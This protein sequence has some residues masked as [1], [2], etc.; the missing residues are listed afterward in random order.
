M[1]YR[2]DRLAVLAVLALLLLPNAASQ[3]QDAATEL[4]TE[5]ILRIET[6]KHD[7]IIHRIDT[8]AENRFAVTASDDKT[9]RVWSLP[10]GRLMRVLR[11]PI[12]Q[13]QIGKIVAVAI[14]PDGTTVAVGGWTGT[15]THYNIFLLDRASGELKQRLRDLRTPST[16][17]PIRPMA[18]A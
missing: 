4:P 6:G 3:A 11:L 8:D 14:S 9:V 15:A 2:R 10:E 18:D 7:A 16:T 5:P 12:D 13:G 1:T 17:W